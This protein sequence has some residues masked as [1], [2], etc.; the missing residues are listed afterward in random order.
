MFVSNAD[1]AESAPGTVQSTVTNTSVP[2]GEAAGEPSPILSMMP[3]LFIFVVFYFLL[4]RPQQKKLREHDGM[5]KA[6]QRGDKIVT[7]GGIIGVV[8]KLDDDVIVLEIAQD[9]RVRVLRETI[10]HVLAKAGVANDNKTD[11]KQGN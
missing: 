10:S 7:A 5:V 6:I 11:D 9:V 4:I 8:H 3:L 1:A 2:T